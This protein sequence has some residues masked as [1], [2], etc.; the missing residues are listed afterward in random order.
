MEVLKQGKT[1]TAREET[2]YGGVRKVV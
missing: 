2:G 1:A